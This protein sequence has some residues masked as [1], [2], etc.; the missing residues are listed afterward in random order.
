MTRS[1]GGPSFYFQ[2]GYQDQ[3]RALELLEAGVG[4]GAIL[5]P[6]HLPNRLGRVA[7]AVNALGRQV[8][9]DPQLYNPN[10]QHSEEYPVI[11]QT[12]IGEYGGFRPSADFVCRLVDF[13]LD[14]G[15]TSVIL[16]MP[17]LSAFST[18]WID[19][20]RRT[21]SYA[22]THLSTRGFGGDVLASLPLDYRLLEESKVR[23]QILDRITALDVDGFY[24]ACAS[25]DDSVFPTRSAY[26]LG[27]MDFIFRLKQNR[28]KVIL[29]YTSY[30][31][32]MFFPFGL[33]GFCSG[34]HSNRRRFAIEEWEGDV[35]DEEGRRNAPLPRYASLNLL[36]TLVY[37]DEP[38][39]LFSRGQWA[40]VDQSPYSSMLFDGQVPSSKRASWK[41]KV[42]FMHYMW[43]CN[44]LANEFAELDREGRISRV[45]GRIAHALQL[46]EQFERH[47][48]RLRTESSGR[49]L[50][51]WRNTFEQYLKEVNEDLQ[52]EYR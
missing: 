13:Q 41:Q 21:I 29:G 46:H 18:E 43:T 32:M 7:D 19:G 50:L 36:G 2:L 34:G 23:Q 44:R 52:D 17:V 10:Y 48:I 30:S 15:V 11:G 45:R 37:P 39:L 4:A 16:P 26:L 35:D 25:P 31:A 47:S 40:E 8:M 1:Y 20:L 6:R 22:Q 42:S 3:T 9:V 24:L 38:D 12:T 33:D 49:H 14:L 51:V 5:S 28:Y 27:Q